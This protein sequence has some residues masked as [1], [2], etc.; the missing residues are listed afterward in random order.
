MDR[1][2]VSL[3]AICGVP[4]DWGILR[5]VGVKTG[6][7]RHVIYVLAL[8]RTSPRGLFPPLQKLLAAVLILST[9]FLSAALPPPVFAETTLCCPQEFS[10]CDQASGSDRV[11]CIRHGHANP[12]CFVGCDYG[13]ENWCGNGDF[14]VGVLLT[15][16]Q[17]ERSYQCDSETRA[18]VSGMTCGWTETDGLAAFCAS[19]D[20]DYRQDLASSRIAFACTE[21][22]GGAGARWLDAAFG[23]STEQ[24]V[25]VTDGDIQT[26]GDGRHY[27]CF[28]GGLD[29]SIK[30]AIQDCLN[31]SA[32]S[33]VAGAIPGAV[34]GFTLGTVTGDYILTVPAGTL[35][36]CGVGAEINSFLQSCVPKVMGRISAG[37]AGACAATFDIQLVDGELTTDLSDHFEQYDLCQQIPLISDDEIERQVDRL[38]APAAKSKLRAE[39]TARRTK[40]IE[41]KQACC[42]CAGDTLDLVSGKCQSSADRDSL[43]CSAGLCPVATPKPVRGVYTAVGCIPSDSPGMVAAIIRIALGLF[44]GIT[45]LMILAGAFTFATAGSDVK[46]VQEAKDMITSAIY[47]L[48][49]II[50]S[51]TILE[52]VGVSILHIP[53]FGK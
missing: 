38:V 43:A 27:A 17:V 6:M 28:G 51:V 15:T 47:A 23:A 33:C 42:E 14:S 46:R 11:S 18:P 7:F 30:N 3:S 39:L 4:T 26:R 31:D 44:G 34:G 2:V 37:T 9:L 45:L 32:Y 36:G 20:A 50:F 19:V 53:G 10:R 5:V 49:F 22:C 13:D 1:A 41:E 21:N 29:G 40:L 8:R 25:N 24:Y 48:L 35:A 52:F 16:D 12:L